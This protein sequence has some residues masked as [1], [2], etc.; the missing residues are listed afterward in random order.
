M[1]SDRVDTVGV[2]VIDSAVTES[3]AE[4]NRGINAAMS[5]LVE[6]TTDAKRRYLVPGSGTLQPLDEHGNPLPVMPGG[7]YDIAFPIQGGGTAWGDDR[8]TRALATVGEINRYVLD[9]QSRDADWLRRHMLGALLDNT[10]WTYA[11]PDLGSLTIQPLANNDTVLYPRNGGSAPATA[12]HYLAQTAA[13]ADATNPYDDL[14][15][16]LRR[17]PSQMNS[18]IVAYIP[19]NLVAATS[20]LAHFTAV[21][22]PRV[23][24][25]SGT[26][27]LTSAGGQF[28]GPGSQVLGITD[29]VW[30]VE[31]PSLPDSYILAVAVD[32]DPALGMREYPAPALQGLFRE[33]FSPDGNH[34][35]Y[36]FLRYAGFGVQNRIGAAVYQVSG[37]DTTYDIPS[38]FSTPIPV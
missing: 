12:Q 3:A 17:Y 7:S 25:G 10:T 9:A 18:D 28:L 5:V 6:R 26:A 34:F 38:G 23:T 37:G 35:A 13:V 30:I 33:N 4:W 11:D 29:K 31:W 15:S 8:V 36:R 27:T 14:Y 32:A 16:L 21:G 24:P 22:D 19:T 2:G 20:A 1:F